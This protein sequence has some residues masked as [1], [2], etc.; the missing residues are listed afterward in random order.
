VIIPF[1]QH[2]RPLISPFKCPGPSLRDEF[3]QAANEAV[4]R[5]PSPPSSWRDEFIRAADE[6][7]RMKPT[8]R[9]SSKLA[10]ASRDVKLEA[11]PGF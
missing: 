5:G 6:A 4:R 10:S 1:K 3:V 9:R 2:L 8:A 11:T 7:V